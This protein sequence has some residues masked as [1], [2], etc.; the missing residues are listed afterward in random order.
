MSPQLSQLERFVKQ[1]KHELKQEMATAKGFSKT[2]DGSP[3]QTYYDGRH[4]MCE[5]IHNFVIDE[6]AEHVE[7][8]TK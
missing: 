2:Y 4:D 3:M 8:T 1:F 7:R 6:V 5:L